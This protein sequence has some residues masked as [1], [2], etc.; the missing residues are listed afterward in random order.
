MQRRLWNTIGPALFIATGCALDTDP[1]DG[2]EGADEALRTDSLAGGPAARTSIASNTE[3]FAR[4]SNPAVRRRRESEAAAL[5]ILDRTT[6]TTTT[7]T[8]PPPSASASVAPWPRPR[9]ANP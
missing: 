1:L 8:V 4:R 6:T 2:S 3:R 7:T 5:D 9:R